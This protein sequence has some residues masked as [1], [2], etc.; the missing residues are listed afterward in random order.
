ME[1]NSG[2]VEGDLAS[3][4]IAHIRMFKTSRAKSLRIWVNGSPFCENENS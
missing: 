1:T 4:E 2:Q 3:S